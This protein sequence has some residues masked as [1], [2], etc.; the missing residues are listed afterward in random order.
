MFIFEISNK[1]IC[2]ALCNDTL[3]MKR[4]PYGITLILETPRKTIYIICVYLIAMLNF[5]NAGTSRDTIIIVK[6]GGIIV[7]NYIVYYI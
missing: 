1:I 6:F 4:H 3:G 2:I 5:S 7:S